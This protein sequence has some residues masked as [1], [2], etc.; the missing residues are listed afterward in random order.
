MT[1]RLSTILRL[2]W[3]TVAISTVTGPVTAPNCVAWRAR[4]ATFALQISF[5]L[6]RQAMLGHDPPIQRRS[7]TAVR[8]PAFGQAPPEQLAALAA[9]EDQ[10][11]ETFGSGHR[12]SPCGLRDM[13]GRVAGQTSR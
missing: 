7:T 12:L 4:W 11:F 1:I 3:R 13:V 8:R 10:G 2:R 9:A 5:L 6:G